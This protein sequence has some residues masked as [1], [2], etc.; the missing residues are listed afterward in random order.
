MGKRWLIILVCAMAIYSDDST[1]L[2]TIK[3]KPV[4]STVSKIDLNTVPPSGKP[5]LTAGYSIIGSGMLSLLC[6][7]ACYSH[8]KNLPSWGEPAIVGAGETQE[9]SNYKLYASIFLYT[10]LILEASSVPFLV[11]GYKKRKKYNAFLERNLY[12]FKGDSYIIK[13][14]FRF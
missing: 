14:C 12:G 9:N 8:Y 2:D 10:G 3:E 13:L 7:S 1:S 11:I 5:H 4:D 6:A